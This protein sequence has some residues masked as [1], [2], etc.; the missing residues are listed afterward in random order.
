MMRPSLALCDNKLTK[1]YFYH[2]LLISTSKPLMLFR[3]YLVGS[4]WNL[5]GLGKSSTLRPWQRL[6]CRPTF[7]S[8]RLAKLPF[9]P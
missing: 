3:K 4:C 2:R 8:T 5:D 7:L 1:C 6:L 9:V